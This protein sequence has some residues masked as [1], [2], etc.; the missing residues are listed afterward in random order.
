[1]A[2]SV[3]GLSVMRVWKVSFDF[4][5]KI[6]MKIEKI[7]SFNFFFQYWILNVITKTMLDY[8]F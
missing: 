5:F 1:M 7:V 6:E 2:L 4:H 8:N 3:H